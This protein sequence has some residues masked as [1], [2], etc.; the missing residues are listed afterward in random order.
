M[1]FPVSPE[2]IFTAPRAAREYLLRRGFDRCH[3]LVRSAVIEDF[4]GIRED[5]VSPRAVVVGDMGEDFTYARL[6]RAFRLLLQGAELVTLA[7]NRY[8]RAADGFVLDQGPFVAALENASGQKATLVGKPSIPFFQTALALLGVSASEAAVV[9]DD[10]DVDV[11]GGQAAG[12]RGILVQTGKFREE[13]LARSAI[14]PD[15]ILRSLADLPPLLA[16]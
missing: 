11:G 3:L 6:N 9:G 14:R 5:D 15:A 2:R 4:A 8:Y 7:Q 13:E 12:L 1:G 10:V 16:P